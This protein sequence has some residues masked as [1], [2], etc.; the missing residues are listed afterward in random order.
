MGNGVED[1]N[2]GTPDDED[3]VTLTTLDSG[4][5]AN[6]PIVISGSGNLSAW[7]DWNIDGDLDDGG[8]E[9]PIVNVAVTAS[10]TSRSV[11]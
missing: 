8:G 3:G 11:Q 10:T 5:L 2:T 7:F 6:I 4:T 1:D 9:N